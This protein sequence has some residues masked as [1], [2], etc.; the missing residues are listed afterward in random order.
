MKYLKENA[1]YMKQLLTKWHG[2]KS[3]CNDTNN[4][5]Y[6]GRGIKVCDEWNNS[7]YGFLAF[8]TWSIT[9]GYREGLTIDRIDVNG[10]YEPN[11]CRYIT[12]VEQQY[13][14]RNTV[15]V[16]YNNKCIQLNK[17]CHL[18]GFDNSHYQS[19]RNK[20]IKRKISP[21]TLLEYSRYKETQDIIVDSRE[22]LTNYCERNNLDYYTVYHII[23]YTQNGTKL[24]EEK[25]L[26]LLISRLYY[27]PK[28]IVP[29]PS[30]L[31]EKMVKDIDI[32]IDY[33]I[34]LSAYCH[35][36]N[37]NYKR[38]YKAIVNEFPYNDVIYLSSEDIKEILL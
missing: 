3:R 10:N 35:K 34:T 16:W 18:K 37:L 2:M 33:S 1:P 24:I 15:W 22:H 21:I 25:I 9:H 8:Y 27:P 20:I 28:K 17:Y 30:E 29:P 31:K 32:W 14:K 13:N 38:A 26:K 23:D 36:K 12:M 6:G 4:P 5:N 11:N 19:L 7:E